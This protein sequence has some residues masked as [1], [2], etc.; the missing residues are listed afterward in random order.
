MTTI[1]EFKNVGLNAVIKTI[2]VGAMIWFRANDVANAMC[3]S[4][5]R[6]AVN[7]HVDPEY[8]DTLENITSKIGSTETGPLTFNDK[9]T[10]YISEPGMYQLIFSSK[11]GEAK[12]FT[13]WVV[14]DVLPTIRKTGEYKPKK[15]PLVGQQMTILNECDLHNK[16]IDFIRKKFKHAIIVPG[17]GEL[18]TSSWARTKAYKAGY[19]GGQPDILILNSH[20]NYGGLAIEL[21]TPTGKGIVS[22]KQQSFL[23]NLEHNK[24]KTIVSNDYDEVIIAVIDYFNGVRIYCPYCNYRRG[25]KNKDNYENHLKGFHKHHQDT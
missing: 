18:Q 5:P 2:K 6:K 1:A 4:R 25:F 7:D 11:K 14:E 13:K 23:L 15:E 17:L 22:D 10:I 21:K 16:V 9:Q 24:F 20:I 8:K 3:Y 12:V 19:K